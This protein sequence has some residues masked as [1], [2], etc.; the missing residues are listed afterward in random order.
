MQPLAFIQSSGK[1][2]TGTGR[3]RWVEERSTPPG[4][5][6]DLVR[7]AVDDCRLTALL[8]NSENVVAQRG[9]QKRST[10]LSLRDAMSIEV[11]FQAD[12]VRALISRRFIECWRPCSHLSIFTL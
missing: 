3:F 5:N 10:F 6:D 11:G 8:K 7:Q 1:G 9:H 2:I 4:T 12:A